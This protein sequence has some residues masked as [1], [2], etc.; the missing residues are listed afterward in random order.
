MLS[1]G[2]WVPPQPPPA[3]PDDPAAAPTGQR[4]AMP[5]VSP[6]ILSAHFARVDDPRLDGLD[7][8]LVVFNVE[9][10]AASLDRRAFVVSRATTGPV[11]PRRAILAPASEDDENRTVLLVGEF[12]DA[13]DGKAPTHVAVSGPLFAEDGGSLLGLG[14]TIGPFTDPLRIVSAVMLPSAPGRCEGAAQ[15]LRT[16]WDDELRGVQPEDLQRIRVAGAQGD[17]EHPL[18]L[19]DHVTDHDE[20]GQDNVLDLCIGQADPIV[21]VW[22]EAGA[23]RDAAGHP[24]AAIELRMDASSP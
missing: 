2:C 5:T 18:R 3:P 20:A 14:A 11:R 21:R 12:G 24:S 6:V 8:L 23:F 15:S 22:V 13:A 7:G 16:Y 17:A 4:L 10:D 19:D 1:V 9:V